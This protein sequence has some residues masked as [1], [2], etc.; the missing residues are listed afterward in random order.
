MHKLSLKL[1]VWLGFGLMLALTCV[2][3]GTSI[4]FLSKVNLQAEDIV[5]KAQPTM[6][7]AL[8]IRADLNE[9]ARILNA[10]I[11]S[12]QQ[13]DKKSMVSSTLR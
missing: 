3:A 13:A 10:Y 12:Q 11:I 9:S 4:I 6:I 2:I 5:N 8:N 7:N 1:Q